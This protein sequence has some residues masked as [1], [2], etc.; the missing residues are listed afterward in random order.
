MDEAENKEKS[1]NSKRQQQSSSTEKH[2]SF[3]R[4]EP[5]KISSNNKNYKIFSEAKP[6][7]L[8]LKSLAPEKEFS[9][10]VVRNLEED[11]NIERDKKKLENNTINA[12][13]VEPKNNREVNTIM[14]NIA[15]NEIKTITFPDN[16]NFA[17][18]PRNR[19]KRTPITQA[20]SRNES[21]PEIIDLI[22]E[23][24]L[25]VDDERENLEFKKRPI[26]AIL[27]SSQFWPKQNL[28]S[29]HYVHPPDLAIELEHDGLFVV[30][31]RSC[32]DALIDFYR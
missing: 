27:T 26:L 28:A 9:S 29:I 15:I 24:T 2:K 4:Q 25:I 19:S 18:S 11:F 32:S 1:T 16:E 22:N 30:G 23:T 17:Y 3:R 20:L 21:N 5:K 31:K 13:D 12:P 10:N 8:K 7:D 14:D 6:A